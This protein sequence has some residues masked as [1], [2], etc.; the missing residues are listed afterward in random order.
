[1]DTIGDLLE[2]LARR[3][4]K[5]ITTGITG[6]VVDSDSLLIKSPFVRGVTFHVDGLTTTIKLINRARVEPDGG[7]VRI[8]GTC[9]HGKIVQKERYGREL[10][11]QIDAVYRNIL[12]SAED[13]ICYCS[14]G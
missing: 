13:T 6:V 7:S 5:I 8:F 2:V 14:R 4:V 12:M 11:H 1:M 9:R 10:R 3:G